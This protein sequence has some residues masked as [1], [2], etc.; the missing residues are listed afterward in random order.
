M[1]KAERSGTGGKVNVYVTTPD[2]T[3]PSSE[4]LNTIKEKLDP[5]AQE[6]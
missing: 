2:L 4:L 3:T 5:K 6:G 1:A